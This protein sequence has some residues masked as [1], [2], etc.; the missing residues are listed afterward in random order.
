MR[1]LKLSGLKSYQLAIVF[2][3]KDLKG[4]HEH[5]VRERESERMPR[6]VVFFLLPFII[7][8]KFPSPPTMYL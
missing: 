4:R 5:E 7:L 1:M 8:K 6:I 3:Y 2:S